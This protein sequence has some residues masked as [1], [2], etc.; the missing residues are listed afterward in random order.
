MC[1]DLQ[2][3]QSEVQDVSQGSVEKHLR[4]SVEGLAYH[5]TSIRMTY[6]YSWW[7]GLHMIWGTKE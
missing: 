1:C 3:C 7:H 4:F 5:K 2:K 6:N